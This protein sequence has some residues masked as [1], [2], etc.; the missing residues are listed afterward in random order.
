MKKNLEKII[1]GRMYSKKLLLKV[2]KLAESFLNLCH[3]KPCIAVILVGDNL[4]SKIYVKNKIKIA[5]E[6]FIKSIP[7]SSR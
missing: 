3:R 4:A 1:D 2:S 7:S 5:K 6:S